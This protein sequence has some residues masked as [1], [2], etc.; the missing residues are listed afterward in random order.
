MNIITKVCPLLAIAMLI[1]VSVACG[2]SGVAVSTSIGT[3]PGNQPIPN[4]QVES[5]PSATIRFSTS[6]VKPPEP[7]SPAESTPTATMLFGNTRSNPAPF[8]SSVLVEGMEFLVTGVVRPADS[9]VS[10]GNYFNYKPATGEEWLFVKLSVTCKKPS[11]QHCILSIDS[12]KVLGSD[13]ILVDGLGAAGVDGLLQD[14]TFYGGAKVTGNTPFIVT[15]GDKSI[16]LVYQSSL[17]DSFY[18]ALPK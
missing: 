8:G 17:G 13:G 4:S 12:L 2:P 11:D 16:L 5:S 9:I 1:F 10:K 14:I 7:T 18:F 6:T 15:K 3:Q